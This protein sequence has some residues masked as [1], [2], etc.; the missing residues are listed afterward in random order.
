MGQNIIYL[1]IYYGYWSLVV[2]A[3]YAAFSWGAYKTLVIPLSLLLWKLWYVNLSS[4]CVHHTFRRYSR[5]PTPVLR[6][7]LQLDASEAKDTGKESS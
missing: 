6:P 7:A 2:I 4:N 5:R 1:S 3:A